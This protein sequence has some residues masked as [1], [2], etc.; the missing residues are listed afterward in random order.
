MAA[1]FWAFF[2][3]MFLQ[4]LNF[5]TMKVKAVLW[6]NHVRED[7]TCRIMIYTY[8]NRKKKYYNTGLHVRPENWS[9]SKEKVIGLPQHIK[10]R[11][12]AALEVRKRN[13]EN[14]LT[15]G[16]PVDQLDDNEEETSASLL[17]FLKQ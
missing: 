8:A 17:D 12:N 16:I 1:H 6:T 11:I 9:E 14:K 3:T 10:N 13:Y 5:S 15:A 2:S 7:G 4:I